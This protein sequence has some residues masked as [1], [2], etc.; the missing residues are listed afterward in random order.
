[1]TEVLN[2]ISSVL[3]FC[4]TTFTRIIEWSISNPILAIG[5]YMPLAFFLIALVFKLVGNLFK[6][7][8]DD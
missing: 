7:D 8:K 5:I 2:T 3:D 6:K 1:M 4:L